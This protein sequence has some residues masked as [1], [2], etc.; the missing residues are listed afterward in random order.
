MF[1]YLALKPAHFELKNI[2][3]DNLQRQCTISHS[4]IDLIYALF[5]K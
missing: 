4:Y 1:I 2:K 5:M 3:D